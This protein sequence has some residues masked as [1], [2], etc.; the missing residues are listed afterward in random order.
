MLRSPAFS[1]SWPPR[2]LNARLISLIS[3][4]EVTATLAV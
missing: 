1:S 3:S 4:F 2:S